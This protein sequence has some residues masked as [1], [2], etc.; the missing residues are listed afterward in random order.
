MLPTLKTNFLTK[1]LNDD[2]IKKLAGAMQ[3]KTFMRKERIIK[4]GDNGNLYYILT[5]GSVQVI[6]Y[7]EG[8]DPDD[9]MID[10]KKKFMKYMN[11]GVGFGELALLYNDKRSAT[12]EAAEDCE[13]YTLDGQIFKAIIVSSS[14]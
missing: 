7:N 5:K 12:I 6:V 9:P 1:N 13:C 3:L 8:T 11:Q 10:N 14:I 2:E 4:Y